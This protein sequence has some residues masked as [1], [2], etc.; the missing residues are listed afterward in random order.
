LFEA[1]RRQHYAGNDGSNDFASLMDAPLL[2]IDDLGTEPMLRN[3]TVEYL[4]L[5]LNARLTARRH[6]VIVT[7]LDLEQL[8]VRYGERVYSRLSDRRATLIMRLTGK[9][10]RQL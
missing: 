6:T 3:I 8:R 9:D 2:L 1:M 7:N 5:L 10:L 4:F